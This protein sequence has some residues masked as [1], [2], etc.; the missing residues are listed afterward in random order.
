MHLYQLAIK[1]ILLPRHQYHIF[2]NSIKGSLTSP[3]K[4]LILK[5]T[6]FKI[7]NNHYIPHKY[8]GQNY[9]RSDWFRQK[10]FS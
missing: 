10:A 5:T 8:R 6:T 3:D 1:N 9:Q 2:T 7:H 4:G